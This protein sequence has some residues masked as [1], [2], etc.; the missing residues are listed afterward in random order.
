MKK[1]IWTLV[2]LVI[3]AIFG[4]RAWWLYQHKQTDSNVV[5]IGLLTFDTGLYA[6]FGQALDKGAI[7]AVEEYNKSNSGIKLDL[8][9]EDGKGQAKDAINAFNRLIAQKPN[10][11]IIGGENQVP[12]VAPMLKNIPAV[13]T[14]VTTL[15][16]LKHNQDNLMFLINPSANNVG[17]AMGE[18]ANKKLNLKNI[19]IL[20]L[21]SS[22]GKESAEGFISGFGKQPIIWEQFKDTNLTTRD[23][24]VKILAEN[25]DGVYVVGHG[26]GF[27]NA[28]KQLK[29]QKYTG[30]IMS[31]YT[32]AD[33][34]LADGTGIYFSAMDDTN[35]MEYV[36]A[37]EK[38]YFDRFKEKATE[39][40]KLG[41]DAVRV[42]ITAIENRG[43]TSNDIKKGLMDIKDMNTFFGKM[44]LNNNG[45][46]EFQMTIK[47]LQPDGTAKIVKE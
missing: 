37:F 3:V 20:S 1:L 41:Y 35:V 12:P 46:S 18:Y 40:S 26:P 45:T 31:D 2:I 6:E 9:I 19:A 8:V 42:I 27:P 33:E 14:S 13:L 25:P 10:A 28:F 34:D 15:G 5:K 24:I 29:E 30:V 39:H 44:K 47:Q 21:N 36:D 16:F 4:G 23:Q 38:K 7:L 22:Y 11:L 17:Y 32:V 43:K